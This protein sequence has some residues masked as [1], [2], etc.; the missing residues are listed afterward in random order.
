MPAW[1]RAAAR[2][3]PP[4]RRQVHSILRH[5]AQTLD[6]PLKHLYET[7]GWPLYRKFGH[8]FD[9][10]KL[11]V[12]CVPRRA[13]RGRRRRDAISR[14]WRTPLAPPP[15][16]LSPARARP[17]DADKIFEDIEMSDEVRDQIL[18]NIQRRL[19][20]QPHRIRAD[21]EVTC[22]AYDGVLAI[23][24]AL[25]AGAE[26]NTEEQP[27]SIKLIAPPLFVLFT[28][29]V[30]K[31]GGIA[32]LQ[33]A[34]DVIKVRASTRRG[35][36]EGRSICT[37]LTCIPRCCFSAQEKIEARGGALNIKMA[38]RGS[39]ACRREGGSGAPKW[40]SRFDTSVARPSAPRDQPARR[41]RAVGAYGEAGGR[42]Q[43]SG[44][45]RR[46]RGLSAC[47]LAPSARRLRPA[48]GHGVVCTL[49]SALVAALALPRRRRVRHVASLSRILTL[50]F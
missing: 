47:S 1:G 30:D 19:T 24:E 46:R 38:V 41:H 33:H 37:C 39:A 21:I 11:A 50:H 8:A 22:F 12:A 7:I 17:S 42:E 44:R 9:A 31:D 5:T 20:P 25:L 6:I 16:A 35:G 13:G 29:S 36:R 48:A 49:G 27:L 15:P 14:R 40:V 28:Q 2:S 10:F 34:I 4:P 45:R 3:P 32:H 23:R 43:G 26:L 18:L